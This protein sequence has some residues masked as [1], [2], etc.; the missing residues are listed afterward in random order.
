LG[1]LRH[2]DKEG[3]S[4]GRT[5]GEKTFKK[6]VLK[7]LARGEERLA[8]RKKKSL[9]QGKAAL[10]QPEVPALWSPR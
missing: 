6:E 8:V 1:S 7:S 2:R 5:G 9:G 10:A 3:R 4:Q